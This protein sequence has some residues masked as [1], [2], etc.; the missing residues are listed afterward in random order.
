MKNFANAGWLFA[1]I[2]SSMVFLTAFN[3]NTNTTSETKTIT[4]TVAD[5]IPMTDKGMLA[6]VRIF[7][8]TFAPRNW[9]YCEGQL[10]NSNQNTALFSILGTTYGGNGHTTF[11]LPDLREAEKNLG[12]AR[13]IICIQGVYP[14]RS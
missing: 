4:K 1:I 14:S 7:A 8:G 6:E 11:A 10:L 5:E 12:G 3:S 13:Y 9:S 2:V